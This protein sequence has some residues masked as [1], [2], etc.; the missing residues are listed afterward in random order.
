MLAASQGQTVSRDVLIDG[1]WGEQLPAD[2]DANLNVLVNRARRALG[3]SDV[4]QTVEG[5]YALTDRADVVVDAER[6]EAALYAARGA[7]GAH[8]HAAAV[9]A[10]DAAL[11]LWGE[12]LPEDA[13]AEW[14]RDK[15]DR[16]DRLHYEALEVSAEAYLAVGRARDAARAA[17]DAVAA[18][19]L[20]ESAYVLLMRA[21]AADGDTAAALSVFGD[22]RTMLDN[23]LG[24]EP[25]PAAVA[26]HEELR[27]TAAVRV[28]V[29][30]TTPNPTNCLPLVGRDAELAAL[31]TMQD[32]VA[33]VMGGGGT[34][35][36][37]LIEELI[38]Q[39][40]RPVLFARALP[41]RTEEPWAVV[42]TLLR[43]APAVAVDVGAAL[44]D[45]TRASLA[46]VLPELG[47]GEVALEGRSR[48]ALMLHGMVRIFEA[49]APSLVVV[50]DLQ[51]ADASSLDLLTELV[52]RARD[53]ALVCGLRPGE[54]DEEGP[55]AGFLATAHDLGA[56]RLELAGLHRTAIAELVAST[57]VVDALAQH[58]DQTPFAVLQALRALERDGMV[59]RI[60]GRWHETDVHAG[61][62][63]AE[64]ARAGQREAVWREFERQRPAERNLAA[65][66]ALAAKP[67]PLRLLCHAT[68]LSDDDATRALSHLRRRHLVRH[69]PRG[70][71]LDHDLVRE[72]VF[73]RLDD[74]VRADVH[75][76][77]ADAF[78]ATDGPTEEVAR[79]RAGS[80]DAAAAAAAYAHSARARL[81]RFA[82][83]EARQLAEEGLT[84]DPTGASLADL[85]EV[86]AETSAR[87]DDLH[88]ARDDLR[89][90]LALT[91]P[92][93]DRARLLTRLA[94]LTFGADDMRRADELTEMALAEAGDDPHAR[95]RA[96]NMRALIDMNMNRVERAIAGQAEALRLF[97]QVGDSAGIAD[98]LD[99]QAMRAFTSGDIS[100]GVERFER[101]A[102]LFADQG[103]W[104]RVVTPRTT[105][106]H[107]LAFAGRPAEGL[108]DVLDALD[109]AR[110]LGYREGEAM[111]LWHKAELLL[112]TGDAQA[113][114]DAANAGI[115]IAR[116]LEHRGWTATNLSARGLV[117]AAL[118]DDAAAV[119]SFEESIAVSE[120]IAMFRGWSHARLASLLVARGDL[121]AAEPHV[122]AS[123]EGTP[124]LPRH[125]ARLAQC[126]LA[127]ARGDAD[128][129]AVVA[130]ALAQAERAGHWASAARLAELGARA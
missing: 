96:T 86:R 81:E 40:A 72:T 34:G 37:R 109:L 91:E 56:T 43:S 130:S 83:D 51:W 45:T 2:P 36:T 119:A 66:L 90:A 74:V 117:L 75:R 97:T 17:A 94:G 89:A 1:L 52:G 93:A 102:Q 21:F 123:L 61:E 110:R 76:R 5:G 19:P 63:A 77:L 3:G 122:R 11:A 118:G 121:A 9:A 125:E 105:R 23:E 12:P 6:F 44:D 67:L 88:A 92:G 64:V 49:T 20:R 112:A 26:V 57:A 111:V 22:L 33:F 99:A 113:A 47:L 28:E 128:A 41:S 104:L 108:V 103:N 30:S 85:L 53:V 18:Q 31:S 14:A 7:L 68:R 107:G 98:V 62:R 106:G 126:E 116:R 58:T 70:F 114:L 59:R 32:G 38:S 29:P 87:R 50:D 84:L 55:V 10:C 129:A 4:V 25:S 65:V 101:V 79:H 124:G 80:G 115:E 27:R 54:F 71:S 69:E 60:G 15:R 39:A 127:V 8:D 13:Y 78:E 73:E 46:E 82:D 95:A 16:L 48:R 24:I 100:A 35:K 42:A 120:H